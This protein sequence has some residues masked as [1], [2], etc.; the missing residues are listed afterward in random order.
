METHSSTQP[1]TAMKEN[2]IIAIF[3]MIAGI[4]IL[5]YFFPWWTPVIWIC[6]IAWIMRL[7]VKKGILCGGI[8]FAVVWMAMSRYLDVLSAT[9]IMDKTG[10][11]LGG[12]SSVVLM[13]ITGLLAFITGCLSGWLGS[14]LG[15]VSIANE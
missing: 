11:L 15:S 10:A 9:D 7:P 6:C 4:V 1:E 8:S 3:L 14:A 13:I 5:N 2:A 12:V